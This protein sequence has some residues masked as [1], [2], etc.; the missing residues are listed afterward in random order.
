MMMMMMTPCV[1]F[2]SQVVSIPPC[3]LNPF[4]PPDPNGPAPDG[5]KRQRQ[6]KIKVSQAIIIIV[7][8]IIIIIIMMSKLMPSFLVC[9]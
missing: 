4:L 2:P 6:R 9:S 3:N 5:R 1:R 7:I 8:I